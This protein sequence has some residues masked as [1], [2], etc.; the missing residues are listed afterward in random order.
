MPT[1]SIAYTPDSDDAFY[2]DALET[3]KLSFPCFKP[4]FHRRSMIDLNRA[5]LETKYDVTA[6]SSVIYPQIARNYAILSVGTSVGRGYGPVLVTK[7]PDIR[8]D[9]AGCKVGVPGIPTTGWFLLQS[10]FP[11]AIPIEL[12]FDGIAEM[13]A[14]ET[15]DAGVM[16]HEEL[17]YY[18][19]MGLGCLMDLGAEWCSRQGL[20]LPV[21]LNVIRRGLGK[22]EME[23]ICQ[24]LRQSLE[25]GFANREEVLGR[26]SR[27]GR[28]TEGQCTRQFVSMFANSDS[29]MLPSDV[30]SALRVLFCQLSDLGFADMVPQ[31]DI[32][33]GQPMANS[34]PHSIK[35]LASA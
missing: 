27:M 4:A 8:T 10:F 13:V 23:R 21:G 26:V 2:Y 34:P 18:P 22:Q 29:Q 17:L 9:L 16:I 6:I 32:I 14:D 30:R 11:K 25:W 5:A 28:G 3:G 31:M 15:L 35:T 7:N 20:P 19:Q 12:P 33:E 1:L 24:T